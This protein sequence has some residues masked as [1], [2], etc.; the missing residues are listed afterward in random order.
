MLEESWTS[1]NHTNVEYVKDLL[2][3]VLP[4]RIRMIMGSALAS[5][6]KESPIHLVSVVVILLIIKFEPNLRYH[7]YVKFHN[8]MARR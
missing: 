4:T 7:L 5:S 2:S 1:Y 8:R 3:E 6:E